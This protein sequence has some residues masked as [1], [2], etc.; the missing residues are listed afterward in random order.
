MY[1]IIG[2]GNPGSKYM[3]TRHNIGFMI[4]DRVSKI[5]RIPLR[6]ENPLYR[7]G[8]GRLSGE[9]ALLA[10][11][12]TFMNRS[13]S[14]VRVILDTYHGETS[15]LI[16]IHD[17]LD[18]PFGEIRI[19]RGGGSG[20]HNGLLSI[21]D[22]VHSAPFVRVRAG[23]GRPP[24]KEDPAEYVLSPFRGEEEAGVDRMIARGAEAIDTILAYGCEKAMSLINRRIGQQTD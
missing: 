12:L 19:K 7:Y 24:D 11:P 23:V 16:V 15:R 14:A 10:T 6:K 17:D 18:I 22:A 21:L 1:F 2:L 8:S 20:G 5:H 13:G 4:V 3:D 9:E